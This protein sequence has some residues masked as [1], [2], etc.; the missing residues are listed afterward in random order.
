MMIYVEPE[1]KF[2]SQHEFTL[3]GMAELFYPELI[4]TEYQ[5]IETRGISLEFM[6][7]DVR[8]EGRIVS[9][10]VIDLSHP[11]T[12]FEK[13]IKK[14]HE[15]RR[16]CCARCNLMK[17][18]GVNYFFVQRIPVPKEKQNRFGCTELMFVEFMCEPNK[19]LLTATQLLP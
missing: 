8:L 16:G 3:K 4:N 18:E 17:L 11:Q 12:K 7:K 19:K 6:G 9:R 15:V 14:K 13:L 10:I 5:I 2:Y 1:T